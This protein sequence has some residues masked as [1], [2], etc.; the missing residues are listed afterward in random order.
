[1][2]L[3][4]QKAGE[5]PEQIALSDQPLTIGRSPKAD[6]VLDDE[7]AS[8]LHCGI[9]FQDGQYYVKDLSSKNGTFLNGEK[10]EF[11]HIQNGD[12]IRVGS[13]T[14]HVVDDTEKGTTTVMHEMHSEMD[15]GKGYH[16]ILHEIV[17]DAKSDA[18]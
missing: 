1:M 8:R 16:T 12:R 6:I 7:K 2:Y 10:I 5:A 4:Y 9:R 15:Q 11:M 17:K 14:L 13:S 3:R 18:S